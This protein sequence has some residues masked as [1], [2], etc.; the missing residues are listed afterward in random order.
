MTRRVTIQT[1]LGEALQFR[2]LRG[3]EALSE[4]YALDIDLLSTDKAIDPK[5]LLGKNATVVVETDGGGRR[6]ING[7]VSRFGLQGQ[8]HSLYSYKLVLRPWLWLATL[9]SDFRI[10][11]SMTV[12]E[13]IQ[14]VLNKY[15][16]SFEIKASRGYRRWDYCVQYHESDHNFI[17]RLC[18]HEG[19]YYYYRHAAGQQTVVF[20][21]DTETGHDSLPGGATIPFHPPEKAAVADKECILTWQ[22]LQEVRSG[23]HYND[24]YDF[25][26]PKADLS[27]MRQNPPG[28]A[29][30]KYEQYEWPGG[31]TEFGDGETYTR[32]RLEQQLSPRH[33]ARATSNRRELSPGYTL[34]LTNHPREDQNQSYLILAVDYEFHEN[35]Q[36]SEG[37]GGSGSQQK[38]SLAL[39]PKS[40]P[41]RPQRKT[42]KPRTHGPQT[43]V[44]VGPA[45]EEI[46]V[47]PYGRVKVQFHWDREGQMDENSSCWV[48]V[49]T[50][51]AGSKFGAVFTP[52][53]GMEVIIDFLNGDPDYPIL[54][55]C[56]YNAANMPPWDLPDNATQSGWLTRSSKGG[57]PGAG[58]KN[59]AGDA[60]AI[61]FEDKAGAEQLWFHAQKDQLT[62]VEHD[63]D[64][65]VGNDRRKTV[66]GNETN[67]IHKNR[68][69]TVGINERVTI[70][71]N[72]SVSIGGSKTE[73]VAAAKA[74]TIGAAKALTIGAAYQVTVGAAM[75]ET[76]GGAK[77]TEVVG[78]CAEVVGLGKSQ[79]VGKTFALDAGD[80]VTVQTGSSALSMKKDGTVDLGAKEIKLHTGGGYILIKNDG[81]IEISGT[82][83]TIKTAGGQVHIDTAGVIKASGTDVTMSAG[84]GKVNVD[85]GGIVD[86]KGPMVKINT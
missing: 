6:Y 68:T 9:R 10:F 25:K 42:P 66:D 73:T 35:P 16:E 72:R 49:S 60:N 44:V 50:A 3:H 79:S 38:F 22:A 53:I 46:W 14:E 40:V 54:M 47:D 64:K 24:D 77:L 57:A 61:R 26:K 81:K 63:E 29:Y 1:P 58:E 86:I 20:A 2:Q 11:Q 34:T 19:I 33:I 59:G 39:Q 17:A 51:W 5:A 85:P 83:I 65:W 56:V 43:A 41:Y 71:A 74:E 31:F 69:E 8:D 70:G 48:R 27:N 37:S 12:P 32:V 45:G 80:A 55:G 84:A 7:L 76:V 36:V 30:D 67:V 62:E 13:I 78:A 18:E 15:G 4:L 82:D 23:R 52:R 28:H 75:N 21:D